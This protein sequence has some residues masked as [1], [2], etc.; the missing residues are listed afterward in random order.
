MSENPSFQPYD[1]FLAQLALGKNSAIS[2]QNDII[3][4]GL[5]NTTPSLAHTK[6]GNLVDIGA[7]GGYPGPTALT[8][9]SRSINGNKWLLVAN[10][11]TWDATGAGFG[12]F[13]HIYL[14]SQSSNATP[15]EQLLLGYW[16]FPASQTVTV[17]YP[18]KIDFSSV[19]GALAISI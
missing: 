10:D 3:C 5:T 11:I 16:S 8:I 14:Y 7:G 2:M 17:P 19:N 6:R 15:S 1:N 13:R 4:V 9:T 12:P 18:L